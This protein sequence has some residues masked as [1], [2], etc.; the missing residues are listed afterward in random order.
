[1]DGGMKRWYDAAQKR[2][3]VRKYE[4][5]PDLEQML[6]LE[7]AAE[8]LCARGVRVAV[9]VDE[10]AF[11][12][13]KGSRIKGTTAFA[14]FLSSDAEPFAVGYIGEAFILECTAMG[15]GT[16]WLGA[17]FSK[18]GVSKAIGLREG[19]KLVCVTPIG[20]PAEPYAKRPRK[21]IEELTWLN[22][23]EYA[24]LPG[25]QRE[26]IACARMA[27]SAINAQ[28]WEFLPDGDGVTVRRAS[29]NFG[30]GALDC[31]IAMLHME[32]GAAHA[33]VTGTWR[34]TKGGRTFV[35]D[36]K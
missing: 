9:A 20:I 8:S 36:V 24:A 14:A 3:S 19:E 33:G 5:E 21:S 10:R 28:P 26:A 35:P 7:R 15:L 22:D 17:N 11:R 34:Q 12:G 27:P 16:C 31:G 13:I 25:W 2:Y 23:A 6:A 29:L 1:M 4:S 32:L 18:S 30:F